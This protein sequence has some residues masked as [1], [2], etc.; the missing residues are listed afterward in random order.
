MIRERHCTDCNH[1]FPQPTGPRL[2]V[3]TCPNC[4]SNDTAGI[5]YL[6][7]EMEFERVLGLAVG[8]QLNDPMWGLRP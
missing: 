7:A 1:R 8:E 4:C 6:D 5:P 3:V 2:E